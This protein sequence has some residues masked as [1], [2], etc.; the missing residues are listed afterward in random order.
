M[1]YEETRPTT[2]ARKEHNCASDPMLISRRN[3]GILV[4]AGLGIPQDVNNGAFVQ[5]HQHGSSQCDCCSNH[6]CQTVLL[7]EV[8]FLQPDDME[9]SFASYDIDQEAE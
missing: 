9:K 1:Q 3:A 5:C 7:L 8:N 2:S 6:L 4:A